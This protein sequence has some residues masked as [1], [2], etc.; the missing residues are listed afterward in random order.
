[1]S[2]KNKCAAGCKSFEGGERLHHKD[3]D[4]YPDSL[5]KKI[6]ELKECLSEVYEA[7]ITKQA[8]TPEFIEEIESTINCSKN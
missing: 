6:N 4:F 5:S 8:P 2:N 7:W 3:C 1:M